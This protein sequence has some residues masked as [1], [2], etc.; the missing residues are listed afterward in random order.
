MVLIYNLVKVI[1]VHHTVGHS[2]KCYH[3]EITKSGYMKACFTKFFG[4]FNKVMKLT[5]GSHNFFVVCKGDHKESFE[6]NG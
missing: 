3:L 5:T 2:E 6:R 4:T 1:Y